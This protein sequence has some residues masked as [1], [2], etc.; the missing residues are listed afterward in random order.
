MPSTK[1]VRIATHNGSF[2]ADDV[3]GVA[4]LMLLHPGAELLR[5]RDAATIAQADFAVDV[6]GEWEPARGR[7]D[8]H[9]RGFTGARPG[10][11]VYASAGL[12]W[13]TFGAALVERM[14]G[15]QDPVLA[16]AVA[17][18]LDIELVQHLDRADTGASHGAPGLFGLSALLSQFNATWDSQAVVPRDGPSALANFRRAMEVTTLF[19]KA[20]LDQLR[21]KHQGAR[22]VRDAR[23]VLGGAVLVMPRGSLPWAEVVSVEMPE[24]LFVVYPDSSDNQ[25]Q[26]HVVPVEP[27]SFVARKDLPLPWAG[28]RAADLAAVCGVDDAVFCHNGRFIAGAGSLQGALLMAE[29]APNSGT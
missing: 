11:V 26:V 13:A 7:F 14:F 29:L 23:K 12:V 10:G 18:D 22:L 16:K 2:H 1:P 9:Q 17:A 27:Y 25:F 28:L 15:L 21:A 24:V 6:G 3:F 19:L 5:T 8:H 20:S 4:V